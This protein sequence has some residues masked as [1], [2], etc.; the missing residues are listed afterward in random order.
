MNTDN[1]H[2]LI[3]RYE[4]NM[5]KIYSAEHDELF[6]WRA[7]K[8]WQQEWNKPDGSFP[9]FVERF[10]AAKKDFYLFIDNSRMHPSAGVI[11]LWE[12]EP[13]T[14]EHLFD[15]LF[16]DTGASIPVTQKH[17]DLFLE[18]YETLRQSYFPGN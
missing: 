10:M 7:M 13:D 16:A 14:V 12:K 11:K 9:S 17:M 15:Q 3:D 1:L 4:E 6:K 5:D 2:A 8:T 18:S